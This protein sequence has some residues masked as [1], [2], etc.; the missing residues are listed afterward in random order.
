MKDKL[1]KVFGILAVA[2]FTFFIYC[3]SIQNAHASDHNVVEYQTLKVNDVVE[4]E[5]NNVVDELT[6]GEEVIFKEENNYTL[7]ELQKLLSKMFNFGNPLPEKYMGKI[8][9]KQGLRDEIALDNGGTVAGT[10]HDALDIPCPEGT[11]VY[12]VAD[13]TLTEVWPS[14]GNGGGNYSG[15]PVYGGYI[16]ISHDD[17]FTTGCF[18]HLSL[19]ALRE[20]TYVH[21]G[22]LIGYSGGVAGK[23]GSGKS[24]GPHLHY[25]IK[26]NM[27]AFYNVGK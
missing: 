7:L 18:A 22:D 15:H 27:N 9:S 19:T 21:K 14:I 17:G 25:S 11:P 23:R 26:F 6:V 5:V 2:T 3:H 1:L 12:A 20:G 8:S 4:M 16:E 10:F 24:T 13:G